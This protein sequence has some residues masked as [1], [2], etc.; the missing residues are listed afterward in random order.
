MKL[1]QNKI[2][3]N[4]FSRSYTIREM[5]TLIIGSGAAGLASAVR[6]HANGVKDL[7]IV[8]EGLKMGTS[9]NTGSDKQTYYKLSLCAD[10]NDSPFE[11]ARTFFNGGSVHG[12]LA[13]TEASLSARG[14]LHLADIGV[15]FP[16]DAYGQFA[17]YKTDH[18]PRRRATSIGPYTSRQMCLSLIEEIKQR[19]IPVLAKN[20]VVKLMVVRE[21]KKKRVVGAV[22]V[23]DNGDV[24]VFYASNVVFATGGPGGL[25]KTSVYPKVHTGAIGVALQEG[26]AAR[27]LTESQYGLASTKFR[28]NVS[29][30]YMQVVPRIISTDEDGQSDVCEFMKDY[31]DSFGEMHSAVF[32]KGYQW[33][34]D[35]SKV[36][37]G[38]SLID[39]LVYIETV[40]K[41][42]RVFLD[43][44]ENS[45]DFQLKNLSD[46]TREYLENSGALQGTPIE[47]LIHMNP[48][49]Y[50]LYKDHG[51]DISNEFLE[52][53]VC[54]QHNNGGLAGNHWWESENV[55]HFFP[56]G[57]VNGSHGICRPGGSALNAGQVGAFRA[58]EFI[59]AKYGDA[60]I[61]SAKY[62]K[63]TE[64]ILNNIFEMID[65]S[66]DTTNA[67]WRDERNE[68]QE[69]MTECGAHIRSFE[70][71]EEGLKNA[72]RHYA[73]LT[74]NASFCSR[75]LHYKE[76]FRNISLCFAQIVYLEAICFALSE[77]V[78]SRGSA[79][80]LDKK[81]KKI[82][83]KLDDIWKL[84]PENMAFR[85]KVMISEFDRETPVNNYWEDCRKI[86]EGDMWFENIWADFRDGKIYDEP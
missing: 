4:D 1:K 26:A 9:I 2:V 7:L 22:S 69:R 66:Q 16:Q 5:H 86:P 62:L 70:K 17:G 57:E 72:W 85:N 68:I 84:M 24:N 82:H 65:K 6:L 52:V 32:M 28:W 12:D 78:G 10:D 80:V 33:P 83:K 36:I 53:A 63:K 74:T 58:A 13:L 79:M 75:K 56:V 59:S 41:G 38:S 44:M 20:T 18:D 71:V 76:I 19:N 51:I 29:G 77:G 67:S 73:R 11:M 25:Y 81:G 31:Y 49:A 45:E 14:F 43:Y 8:T 46:E 48:D 35:T 23:D 47:R 55:A 60:D 30:T 39:I 21:N 37:G 61:N 54:A 40:I 50:A 64:R 42:R 3:V 15:E 27:N 34:F